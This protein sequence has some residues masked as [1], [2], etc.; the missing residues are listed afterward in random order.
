MFFKIMHWPLAPIF[1]VTGLIVLCAVAFPW[2][3]WMTWKD[4]TNIS[5]HFIYMV[6]TILLI[7][8]PGALVSL[9]LQQSYEAGFFPNLER[10]QM[11]N[12]VKADQ[13]NLILGEYKDSTVYPEMEQIHSR[14]IELISYITDIEEKMVRESEGKPGIPELANDQ[15][16]ETENGPVI[17]Y[18]KLTDPF[19]PEPVKKYLLVGSENRQNLESEIIKYTK[20]L[21]ELQSA[22]NQNY[23]WVLKAS[24]ELAGLLPENTNVSLMS[25]LHSLELMKNTLLFIESYLLGSFTNK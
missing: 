3:T 13:N 10:Q 25:G 15:I 24:G 14:T 1:M 9:N 7:I 20:F 21:S 17:L 23:S 19:T 2:F 8:V 4:D 6:L 12:N 5:S 11:I 18:A 16:S 22:D